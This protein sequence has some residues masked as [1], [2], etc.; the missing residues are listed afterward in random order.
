M[1]K[2]IGKQWEEHFANDW[3]ETFPGTL[4]FRLHDQMT[5]YKVVS[6]NPCDYICFTGRLL[7]MAECK[8]HKGASLPFTDIRQYDKLVRYIGMPSVRA[9][10]FLWLSEKDKI[11]YIPIATVKQL[12]EEGEASV[13]LRHIGNPKYKIYEIPATKLRVFVKGDYSCLVDTLE[14]E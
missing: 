14:G 10:V 1:G 12:K 3:A 2:D 9:G 13:G 4:V 7:F 6:A 11:F 5:G 8:E